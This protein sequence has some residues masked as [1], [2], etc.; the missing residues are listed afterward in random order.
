VFR[1]PSTWSLSSGSFSKRNGS[2]NCGGGL[3]AQLGHGLLVIFHAVN[4][5]S[6]GFLDVPAQGWPPAEGVMSTIMLP[7]THEAIVEDIEKTRVRERWWINSSD[8]E[9]LAWG[10]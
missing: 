9:T 5:S 10:I 6:G 4:L 8:Y 2:S 7:T 1:C 3:F